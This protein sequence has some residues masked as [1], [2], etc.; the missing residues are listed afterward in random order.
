MKKLTSLRIVLTAVAIEN[1]ETND[2]ALEDT[3]DEAPSTDDDS[4]VEAVSDIVVS[5]SA[6]ASPTV[7]VVDQQLVEPVPF[8]SLEGIMSARQRF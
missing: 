7:L 4:T 6:F 8:Q 3:N 5:P 1:V 2:A